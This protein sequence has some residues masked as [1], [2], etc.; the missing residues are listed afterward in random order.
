M[1]FVP[2]SVPTTSNAFLKVGSM[3]T[4]LSKKMKSMKLLDKDYVLGCVMLTVLCREE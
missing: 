1:V 4:V 2:K 3:E